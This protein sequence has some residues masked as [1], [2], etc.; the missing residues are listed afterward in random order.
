VLALRC[1]R[2]LLKRLPIT[3][4]PMPSSTWLGDWYANPIAIGRARLILCMSER[5]L[6]PVVLPARELSQLPTRLVAGV[7]DVLRALGVA[8]A[9]VLAEQARMSPIAYAPTK[10]RVVLG[11]MNDFAFHLG[12]ILESGCSLLTAS[13]ELSGTPCSAI[14]GFPDKAT[15]EV[16]SRG[17]VLRIVH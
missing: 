4:E 17:P 3:A 11:T 9:A 15:C 16:F 7:G 5:T 1:T 2:K 13:V 14:D 12:F 8:E 6:L 10:S